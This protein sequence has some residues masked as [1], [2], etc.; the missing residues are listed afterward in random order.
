MNHTYIYISIL[1]ITAT[2]LLGSCSS[3]FK[4]GKKLYEQHCASCHQID[5][6]GLAK[7]YPPL[8]KSD[9]WTANQKSFTT[10]MAGIKELTEFEIANIINYINHEWHPNLE[11]I[12]I[13]EIENSLSLCKEN[14]L[15]LTK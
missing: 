4:Q 12:S 2:M 6:K 7:L 5:G 8:N 15:N 10:P 13:K 14:T 9:Y 3:E 1:L 11:N